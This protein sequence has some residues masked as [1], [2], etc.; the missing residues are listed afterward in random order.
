M[1]LD[2]EDDILP[3]TV[4]LRLCKIV[5]D[6]VLRISED[7]MFTKGRPAV[8]TTLNRASISGHVGGSI[9]SSTNFWADQLNNDG[10]GIGEVRLDRNSWN[11]LKSKWMRC[12]MLPV[13]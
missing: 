12:K 11:S 6:D 2:F 5:G 4:G 1:A 8:M 13:G 9:D 3:E 7:V 10:D